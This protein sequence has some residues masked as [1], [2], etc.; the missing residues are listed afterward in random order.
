M[1]TSAPAGFDLG[2]L[3][4]VGN[5]NALAFINQ[6]PAQFQAT[7]VQGF[8]SAF[9]IAIANSIWLGVIAAGVALVASFV[10]REIPLRKTMGPATAGMAREAAR[11]R[12]QP[13]AD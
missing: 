2:A 4:S 12:A 10:L 8:H 13:T 1:P 11:G 7:F 3:T 6:I 9:T 5:S